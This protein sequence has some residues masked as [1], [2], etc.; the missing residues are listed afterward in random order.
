[1][2]AV[3]VIGGGFTGAAV[4]IGLSRRAQT[5]LDI[6]VIE[7]RADV[8]RG[9]AYSATDRDHR[10]NAPAA[11]HALTTDDTAGF[12][13]WLVETG[14]LERDPE[15][16]ATDGSLFPRRFELGA[17][18]ALTFDQ[19]TAGNPSGS[20]LR[21]VRSRAMSVAQTAEKFHV[22]L[23]SGETL[24]GDLVV[25]TTSNERPHPPAPFATALSGNP[26]FL[27]DPWDTARLQE[28]ERD[29]RV[30]LLG[31]SLTAA[32]VTA[33]ILR[34]RPQARVEVISRTGI[35]PTSRPA[36]SE[37]ATQTVWERVDSQPSLFEKSHG[38]QETV[39]DVLRAL[40]KDIARRTQKGM[41]WQPAF[42]EL[43]DSA[44]TVWMGLSLA[45][46]RRFQRHLRRHYD[47]CRFRYPPQTKTILDAAER[48]GRLRFHAGSVT[49][50]EAVPEGVH[51]TWRDR[52]SGKSQSIAVDQVINCTGLAS[53]P[54]ASENPFLRAALADGY[55]RVA[56][57][58]IGLDVDEACRAIGADG[59]ATRG[60]FIVGPL[61]F[62]TFGYCL[63]VPYIANQVAKA[64]PGMLEALR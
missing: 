18:A 48:S 5:P 25:I 55:C 24:I 12:S 19:H 10:I 38:R 13:R 47:A 6:A 56:P 44:R 1:M 57:L 4:A 41:P 58:G 27:V 23:E 40:R 60:L 53:R 59:R 63:G 42:D 8:G 33:S 7:P 9:V 11:S 34:E 61:T 35:R 31:A 28:I 32:D 64:L 46:R 52:V 3:I 51:I 43:R 39:L 17:F 36:V 29:G 22:R 15:M 2:T 45:E 21:H 37:P 16:A 20:H 30:L 49:A 62:A 54:D 14:R 50:V 26:R